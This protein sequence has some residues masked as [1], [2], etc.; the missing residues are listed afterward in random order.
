MDFTEL[1]FA[2]G[3][4]KASLIPLLDH[5]TEYV[6]GFAIGERANEL[7]LTAW[8]TAQKTLTRLRDSLGGLIV[9][10]DQDAGFL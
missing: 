10:Q 5:R 9:H 7:A 6:A 4:R 3:A 1:R 8:T 2:G